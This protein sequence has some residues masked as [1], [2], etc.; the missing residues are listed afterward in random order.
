MPTLADRESA[1]ARILI[2]DDERELCETVAYNLTRAGY[3]VRSVHD[4][5]QALRIALDFHPDLVVLDLMMPEIGGLEVARRLRETPGFAR[6]PILMLTALGDEE[7]EVR[8]LA[9]GADDYVAKPFSMKVLLARV[10]ALLR[11]AREDGNRAGGRLTL[12]PIE[13]DTDTHEVTCAGKPMRLTVTEFRLL[14]ALLAAEGKVLSRATLIK[15]AM[16]PGV[17]VTER[18]I[19]VHITSIR[20]KLGRE[21]AAMIRTVRGVGYRATLEEPSTLEADSL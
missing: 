1:R 8:G 13:I 17:T 2:A 10:E 15:A 20:R 6:T 21:H 12:G 19:D 11:R 14:A 4:G 9:A 16:G 3:D 18:T 5:R 7:A